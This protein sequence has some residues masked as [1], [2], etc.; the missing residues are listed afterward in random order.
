MFKILNSD[1][2]YGRVFQILIVCYVDQPFTPKF[3]L[4]FF[5]N[6][7]LRKWVIV[8]E[9]YNK[10]KRRTGLNLSWEGEKR[11]SSRDGHFCEHIY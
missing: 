10:H 2:A 9:Y 1:I 6:V 3:F 8:L 11:S 5:V 4:F 7:D